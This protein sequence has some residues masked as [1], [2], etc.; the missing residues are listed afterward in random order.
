MIFREPREKTLPNGVLIRTTHA[1]GYGGPDKFTTRV[2]LDNQLLEEAVANDSAT[3]G[4]QR[5]ALTVLWGRKDR[6]E[7][8]RIAVN[9]PLAS[10][11]CDYC[12]GPTHRGV[13][14]QYDRIWC[15]KPECH[16]KHAAYAAERQASEAVAAEKRAAQL[17]ADRAEFR[18]LKGEGLGDV[19]RLVRA[20]R[21]ANDS[22]ALPRVVVE[23]LARFE[24][25]APTGE[26][27]KAL[28]RDWRYCPH[29]GKP[30]SVLCACPNWCFCR[31]GTCRPVV[32]ATP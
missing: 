11:P 8:Q 6:D 31:W 20:L 26:W 17:A 9:R 16:E 22:L 5:G 19:P 21:G 13:T 4:E 7:V 12:G 25:G 14:Y 32:K 27:P 30:A 29:H 1:P 2:I 3:S 10:K 28:G 18:R 24:T 23:A 15:R